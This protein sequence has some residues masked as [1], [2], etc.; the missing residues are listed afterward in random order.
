MPYQRLLAFDGDAW[1]IAQQYLDVPNLKSVEFQGRI[2]LIQISN[3]HIQGI[4]HCFESTQK[5]IKSL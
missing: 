3:N 2:G 5:G 4:P 1:H